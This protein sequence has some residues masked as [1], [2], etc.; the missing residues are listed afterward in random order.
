[1]NRR[2]RGGNRAEVARQY[3][4]LT[5]DAIDDQRAARK[6]FA[7]RQHVMQ[8]RRASAGRKEPKRR[9]LGFEPGCRAGIALVGVGH[10]RDQAI[11]QAHVAVCRAGRRQRFEIL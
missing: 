2:Q 3:R 5:D 8:G 10:T 4:N 11:G 9:R 6:S 1:M 7:R